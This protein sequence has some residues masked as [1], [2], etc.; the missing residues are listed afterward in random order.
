MAVLSTTRR[1]LETQGF[2]T[3]DD[4][5]LGELAPWIEFGPALCTTFMGLGTLL[6]SPAILGAQA[7]ASALARRCRRTQP[8]ACG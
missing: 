8:P 2:T 3:L 6:A 7:V 1:R 5:A 4:A